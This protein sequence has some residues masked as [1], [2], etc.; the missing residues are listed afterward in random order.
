MAGKRQTPQQVINQPGEAEVALAASGAV[1]EAARQLGA[2]GQP[3]YRWR[4]DCGGPGIDRASRPRPLKS[5][6]S[7]P[8]RAAAVLTLDNRILR[9]ASRGN[10]WALHVVA[11]LSTALTTPL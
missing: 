3:F 2:T 10:L 5:E 8:Q 1:A 11:G 7:R 9:E 4:G 6:N